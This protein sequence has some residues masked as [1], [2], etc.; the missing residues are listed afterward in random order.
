MDAVLGTTYEVIASYT[1]SDPKPERIINRLIQPGFDTMGVS[2][3]HKE[4][5]W[6]I[7]HLDAAEYLVEVLNRVAGLEVSLHVHAGQMATAA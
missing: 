7:G 3:G 5:T 2:Q 4:W 1:G 6:D